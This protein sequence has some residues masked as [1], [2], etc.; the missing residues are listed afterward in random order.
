MAGET[1]SGKENKHLQSVRILTIE[2]GTGN[3][4][5]QG[6]HILSRDLALHSPQRKGDGYAVVTNNYGNST[7]VAVDIS[8]ERVAMEADG[9]P[10]NELML[11][12][13]LLSFIKKQSVNQN[14][15][16]PRDLLELMRQ[17]FFPPYLHVFDGNLPWGFS[18]GAVMIDAKKQT[19]YTA[20]LGTNTVAKEIKPGSK[21]FK[22]VI[23][24][25]PRFFMPWPI[26]ASA[27]VGGNVQVMSKVMPWKNEQ[28]LIS[29]DGI[30]HI[31][32]GFL[33][34]QSYVNTDQSPESL[35]APNQKEGLYLVL[36]HP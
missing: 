1:L 23:Y 11:L 36:D 12:T 27:D 22:P 6:V 15:S 33:F 4:R 24:P 2:S 30:T 26:P 25:N 18:A 21:L 8:L 5:I 34:P 16:K 35:L 3:H 19:V 28:I 20:C 31:K 17:D 10:I 29:T 7:V 13:D 32:K 9:K 14:A